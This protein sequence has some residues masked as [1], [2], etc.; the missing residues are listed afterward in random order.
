MYEGKKKKYQSSFEFL[1]KEE[2]KTRLV[3]SRE[4]E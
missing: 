2:K 4:R 3:L 1:I